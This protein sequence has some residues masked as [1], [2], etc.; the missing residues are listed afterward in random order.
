MT[1]FHLLLSSS[2][3]EIKK[4]CK[5]KHEMCG[6]HSVFYTGIPPVS[7]DTGTNPEENMFNTDD[8]QV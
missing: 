4:N 3:R 5:A 1:I 2:L 6:S 7:V 8:K